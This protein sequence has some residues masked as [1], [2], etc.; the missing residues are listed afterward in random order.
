[1]S[2]KLNLE[3]LSLELPKIESKETRFLLGGSDY[4]VAINHW[5]NAGGSSQGDGQQDQQT[6]PDPDQG[7]GQGQGTEGGDPDNQGDNQTDQD[8]DQNQD[9]NQ[10]QDQDQDQVDQNGQNGQDGQDQQ[11]G[12]PVQLPN[13]PA[14]VPQQILDTGCVPTSAEFVNSVFG[15]TDT[16]NDLLQ[17][18]AQQTGLTG[19][20]LFLAMQNGLTPAQQDSFITTMFQ[21]DQANTIADIT[22]A[23]DDGHPVMV[24]YDTGQVDSS[25]NPIYHQ[26]TVVGYDQGTNQ[27]VVADTQSTGDADGYVNIDQSA[28]DF[29]FNQYIITGINP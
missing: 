26:V 16:E 7:Q 6:D 14:T 24:S 20:D 15:G 19:G 28:V 25:G 18:W 2:K 12:A 29:N 21:T 11:Q 1:M 23:I 27:F 10:D 13:L 9:Q 17:S 8:Q 4:D 3:E 5:W 22:T